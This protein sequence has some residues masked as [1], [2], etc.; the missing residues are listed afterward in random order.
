MK[1]SSLRFLLCFVFDDDDDECEY[2]CFLTIS[3]FDDT[4]FVD[5]REWIRHTWRVLQ[6]TKGAATDDNDSRYLKHVKFC[7]LIAEK[8]KSTKVSVKGAVDFTTRPGFF[9]NFLLVSKRRNARHSGQVEE[10]SRST[11]RCKSFRCF[12]SFSWF[13]NI[14]SKS[15][16]TTCALRGLSRGSISILEQTLI[17]NSLWL[18]DELQA[19]D[20]S[21]MEGKFRGSCAFDNIIYCS[22]I[23]LNL[24]ASECWRRFLW[25]E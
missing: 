23:L 1:F 21:F 12:N 3:W 4:R 11:T 22:L 6:T 8:Q 9:Y 18:Y 14:N 16:L 5:D 7:C 17:E 25:F 13:Y 19:R 24:D 15:L 2:R 10:K 20:G